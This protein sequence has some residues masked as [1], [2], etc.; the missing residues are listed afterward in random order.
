MSVEPNNQRPPDPPMELDAVARDKWDQL[1]TL[2]WEHGW[3]PATGDALA[4]YCTNWSRWQAAE[5]ELAKTGPVIESPSGYPIQSPY[6]SISRRA[7]DELRRWGRI[8]GVTGPRRQ[9][10]F[11]D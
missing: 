4:S 1:V 2:V 10:E 11:E 3:N 9:I 5:A 8:I 6:L 7:Q